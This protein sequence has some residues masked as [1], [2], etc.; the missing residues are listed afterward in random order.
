MNDILYNEASMLYTML[1]AV[2]R[3]YKSIHFKCNKSYILTER[4]FTF[5]LNNSEIKA[6]R[7]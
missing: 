2:L 1:S 5:S 6:I 4:H 7:S 3:K